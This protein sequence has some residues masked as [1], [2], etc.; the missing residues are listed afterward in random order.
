M[1]NNNLYDTAKNIVVKEI[2]NWYNGM[3]EDFPRKEI[4]EYYS[5][6]GP[7]SAANHSVVTM[8]IISSCNHFLKKG[9]DS[10]LEKCL[11]EII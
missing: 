8:E 10:M 1:I 4:A 3:N 6:Y 5:L 9:D 11:K 2:F 7:T